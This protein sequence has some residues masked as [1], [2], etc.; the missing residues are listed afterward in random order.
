M[1]EPQ[2]TGTSSVSGANVT[3]RTL[4]MPSFIQAGDIVLSLWL[5][6]GGSGSDVAAATGFNAINDVS[7]STN[8]RME[9]FWGHYT[10]AGSLGTAWTISPASDVVGINIGIR[11]AAVA[12]PIDV[13]SGN[14]QANPFTITALSVT[15]TKASDLLLWCVGWQNSLDAFLSSPPSG[16]TL[17][18]SGDAGGAIG[19]KLYVA[20]KIQ[21]ATGATGNQSADLSSSA[22]SSVAMLIAI[23][24]NQP[25]TTPG[26]PTVTGDISGST[27]D[28]QSTVSWSASTDPESD[29][30]T[31]IV[32]LAEDGT[33]FTQVG[34]TTNTSI[35][36][37]MR[38]KTASTVAKF[39]VK[40]TD[41]A[42]NSSAYA[43]SS[44]FTIQHAPTAPVL[45][46]PDAAGIKIT[47]GV[48]YQ[49][50]WQKS[51]DPNNVDSE[52]VYEIDYSANNG[53]SWT[54][55]TTTAGGASLHNWNTTG[56]TPGTQ[57]LIRIRAKDSTNLFSAYDT[58]ANNFEIKA[59]VA[60]SAP[61]N[62]HAEQP[63]GTTVTVADRALTIRIA[64]T[65]VDEGD[66]QSAHRF[67]WGTDGVSYP[68]D[69][70]WISTANQYREY[71][72]GTFGDQQIY[73]RITT[74]DNA[75]N[76]SASSTF[77]FRAATKP[78]T[79]NITAPTAGSPPT[80][81]RP[82][83]TWTSSGQAAY[84]LLIRSGG[85]G[86]T[87]IYNSNERVTAS[88][89]HNT[90]ASADGGVDLAHGTQYTIQVRIKSAE[91]LWSDYDS[92]TVTVAYSGPSQ[93]TLTVTVQD[94]DARIRLV[95]DNADAPDRNEI[96]MYLDSE[97]SSAAIRIK[98]NLAVDGTFYYRHAPAGRA[99]RFFARAYD[100]VNNLYTDSAHSSAVTQTLEKLSINAVAD[101]DATAV[102]QLI[103]E[104]IDYE[105]DYRTEVFEAEGR[106]LP[107]AETGRVNRQQSTQR[108]ITLTSTTDYD[109]LR[110][111]VDRKV[112]LCVRDQ[113]KEKFFGVIRRLPVKPDFGAATF[114]LV[115]DRVGYYPSGN[116]NKEEEV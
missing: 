2:I 78:A 109:S 23:A 106:P 44:A 20:G 91:G 7:Q 105:I 41:T 36:I 60:P 92:E 32:E 48:T 16:F 93:P 1:A 19:R 25:P 3:S 69:S 42:S 111:L 82:T 95:V 33:N 28:Y 43:T 90:L 45:L 62:L 40:A 66:V 97:G 57:Y 17:Q 18:V 6:S 56:L 94:S 71:A 4:N 30:I 14:A 63:A 88:T 49:I 98:S 24:P 35:I 11:T 12:A 55:I 54:N 115:F 67:E 86:G 26:T 10:G 38:Q 85:G 59:D 37:N 21:S 83:V 73:F 100:D 13:F 113:W 110:L 64:Y 22:D 74:R 61:S 112:T 101:S 68:N 87:I 75:S 31:Y 8:L 9:A 27:S 84:Q 104:D 39:R 89:S 103:N 72:G 47:V 107:F 99:V 65:F 114:T 58:S 70:G 34:S 52:I 96:W 108:V 116:P 102:L 46:T 53:S 81:A 5:V 80:N 29:T 77:N 51:T 79:P 50:T 76:T 15:T